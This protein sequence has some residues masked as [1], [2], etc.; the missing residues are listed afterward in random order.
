MP[1][2]AVVA[3]SS[4]S[5]SSTEGALMSDQPGITITIRP[6][7]DGN[8]LHWLMTSAC[9]HG[10]RDPPFT[11]ARR[12]VIDLAVSNL[13]EHHRVLVGCSCELRQL[14]VEDDEATTGG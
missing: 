3:S 5:P 11:V 6:H 4:R 7:P 1:E 10:R 9:S 13:A 2:P 14:T 12:S 8:D